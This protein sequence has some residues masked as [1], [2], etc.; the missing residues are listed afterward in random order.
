MS[1][2]MS[3]GKEI[4]KILIN[5]GYEAFFIGEAVRCAILEK[6]I[7][8]VD[9]TT[10]AQLANL[11][12]IFANCLYEDI[13][14]NTIKLEY[15]G[16]DYFVHTFMNSV[17]ID[18]NTLLN[19]HYS[20]SLLDDLAN[21]DFSINA[22]AMSHSGKLTDAYDGYNDI[23]KRK[24]THIGNAKIRFSK[25]PELIIKAFALMSELNYNLSKK[26]RKGILR[27]RKSLLNCD[28]DTYIDDLKK[29][30]EGPY[31]KKAII[32][33]VKTNVDRVLPTFRKPLNRLANHYKK[34]SFEEV[35]LM[36]FVLNGNI[37]V[38][39]QEYIED[40]PTFEKIFYLA[41]N[42]RRG[43]YD[44]AML[45]NYGLEICLEANRI[46]YLIGK[47]KKKEKKIRRQWDRLPLKGVNSLE[48]SPKDAMKI[49]NPRDY[50]KIDEIFDEIIT[51]IL[52][53]HIMN[54]RQDIE[55]MVLKLLRKNNIDFNLNG[56]T[57]HDDQ[58]EV[59][60]NKSYYMEQLEEERNG[61]PY[62]NLNDVYNN[63]GSYDDLED[64]ADS[65]TNRRLDM[66]EQRL[67]EQTRLLKEKDQRLQEVENL[68]LKFDIDLYV[69][70]CVAYLD[71]SSDLRNL[72]MDD[73]EFKKELHKFIFEYLKKG[74]K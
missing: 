20:K 56:L 58:V 52:E 17:G 41:L 50:G 46:N 55:G 36:S 21:R 71:S 59:K 9:I 18:K 24:I 28:M 42:N 11:K 6:E 61:I 38:I 27:R 12:R 3:R 73:D 47:A 49:I 5:N 45:C 66:L 25:Q 16:F 44:N 53:G 65:I 30:F 33:M 74:D 37:E 31:A 39:Y 4:L 34:V 35:L 14:E 43:Y 64:D 60:S 63:R 62:N 8:R 2:Q 19:K 10:G 72:I 22:I 23:Q 67:D 68:K 48:Y 13:D 40:Y 15:G 1:E 29:V 51:L 7:T 54:K 69:S 26:T 57:A 32:N 70:K